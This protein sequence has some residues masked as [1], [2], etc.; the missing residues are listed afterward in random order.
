[1]NFLNSIKEKIKNLENDVKNNNLDSVQK[2]AAETINLIQNKIE[3][4]N[5]ENQ[6]EEVAKKINVATEGLKKFQEIYARKFSKNESI[7]YYEK[8]K[9]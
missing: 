9:Y 7:K 5:S 2:L 4:F 1:M 8:V 6:K 3:F